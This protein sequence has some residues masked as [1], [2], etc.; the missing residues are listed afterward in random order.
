MP[1]ERTIPSDQPKTVVTSTI[2]SGGTQIPETCHVLSVVVSKEVNRIPVA[3]IVIADGDPAAQS[4]EMSNKTEFE[5]G[6]EIEIKLGYRS[7]EETVFKGIV[8]K[9]SIKTRKKNSLLIIE[10][11]DKAVKMTAACKSS[12][13]KEM[14]DSD[15][16]EQLI[17]TYGLDKD[18]EGTG[19]EHKQLVQYNC[20]DWD[21]LVCRA[22]A[23]GMLCIPNDGKLAI[24]KPNFSGD[25]VLTVQYGA[26]IHELDAEIDARLQY[27]S[28]KGT[29]WNYTDQELLADVEAEEPAIPTAGNLDGATLANVLGE[30]E[31]MLYHSGKIEE[32]ELQQWVNAKMMK[33]RLAKIRGQV[34]IDG[35]A[36]VAPGQIIEL[37]GVGERFEGKLFVTAV[38]QQYENG[39]WQTNIQFGINPE[40]F[41]QTFNVQQPLA[42]ALLPAIEGLQ[43]GIV[44]QLE[45]DP[46]GEDRILVRIPVVHKDDEGAWCRVSSLDA[47]DERG[48]FFRPE[49]NDEVIVGFINND[50]RHGI[51]LG[52]LNSSAKPAH[53]S[54]KDDNHE[55]GY[56]SRSKMKLIFNDD[57]KSI[58]IET[59]GGH[60]VVIDEDAKKIHLEDMNGNKIILNEDGITIE[61]IKEIKMKAATDL[62]M[63]GGANVNLKGGTQTKVEGGAGAEISS[64][65]ATNVKGS[66][67]NLN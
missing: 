56:Q 9:H 35:T 37:Q 16:M 2:T 18:V 7:S 60:K 48:M 25:T 40:W 24:K 14:K 57:K 42:G 53:L 45:S 65:G 34:K 28:V 6:K 29:M 36:A 55:K 15:V 50:P 46:D 41:A 20:S 3:T 32:P 49:I 59:P 64:G 1:N 58:N 11:R 63:E 61:S 62:K 31:F 10:C 19:I 51:V 66:I 17:D 30:D 44:T 43:I 13:F 54:A 26:T 67:V 27:K 22:D 4:F 23:A 47:G 52:M 39:N 8:V 38:R 33:H 5:P 12:Y 21:F